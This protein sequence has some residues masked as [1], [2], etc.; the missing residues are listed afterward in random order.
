[1]E[2]INSPEFKERAYKAAKERTKQQEKER[3]F[4][5]RLAGEA[6]LRNQG[7]IRQE[8]DLRSALNRERS[9]AN[10]LAKRALQAS[11]HPNRSWV[12]AYR[13]GLGLV[14]RLQAG[15]VLDEGWMLQYKVTSHEN[16]TFEVSYAHHELVLSKTGRLYVEG[17]YR[18]PDEVHKMIEDDFVH[19][20][21]HP[22]PEEYMRDLACTTKGNT[23]WGV[24][25]L[26]DV[27]RGIAE[28]AGLNNLI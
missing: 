27:R 9:L 18:E 23:P 10:E 7:R 25:T 16:G 1:M 14:R 17:M 4:I 13:P 6:A 12:T 5:K 28:F 3:E 26:E 8:A 2:D 22:E 20:L 19:K 21:P 24:F 15:K 11:V